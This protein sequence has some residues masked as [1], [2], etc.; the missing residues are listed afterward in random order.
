[1]GAENTEDYRTEKGG[2]MNDSQIS[3]TVLER[4]QEHYVDVP[5]CK[6]CGQPI[7]FFKNDKGKW[8]VLDL[9]FNRHRCDR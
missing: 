9:D 3:K 2:D 6:N 5:I 7:L 8:V 4:L 1:L